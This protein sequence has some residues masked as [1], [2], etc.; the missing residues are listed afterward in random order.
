[1]SQD[2]VNEVR[3]KHLKDELDYKRAA[4]Y[5][6]V[7]SI[8]ERTKIDAH[9]HREVLLGWVDK[10]EKDRAKLITKYENKITELEVLI[11][12]LTSP[13]FSHRDYRFIKE[14]LLG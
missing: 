3:K 4:N 10:L 8:E 6:E 1:M 7:L 2:K 13:T 5:A 14:E 12:E 11:E 9:R